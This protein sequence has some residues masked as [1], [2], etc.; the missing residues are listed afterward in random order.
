[1]HFHPLVQEALADFGGALGLEGGHSD[2]P[3]EPVHDGEEVPK[4]GDFMGERADQVH[5][6]DLS[7]LVRDPGYVDSFLEVGPLI[8]D[9]GYALV[10]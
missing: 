6:H 9:T 3:A 8:F 10:D 1:M 5:V 7:L 2:E 4:R